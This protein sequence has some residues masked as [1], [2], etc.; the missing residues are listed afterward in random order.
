MGSHGGARLAIS[1]ALG[2]ITLRLRPDAAPRTVEYISKVVASR[3]YDGT[4]FYRS[5]FVIQMGTHGTG[6]QNPYG[7]LPVNET[8]SHVKLSNTRGT[9]AVAHWCAT[10]PKPAVGSPQRGDGRSYMHIGPPTRARACRYANR[11]FRP[12]SHTPAR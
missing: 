11:L 10:A 7:D 8:H 4:S 9:A 12:V 2:T 3:I 1:T 6:K 5:D